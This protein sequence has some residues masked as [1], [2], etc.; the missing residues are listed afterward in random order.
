MTGDGRETDRERLGQLEHGCLTV[1]QPTHD[2]APRRVRQGG[3][4]DV[5]AIGG[6]HSHRCRRSCRYFIGWLFNRVTTYSQGCPECRRGN[7]SKDR[8]RARSA[9]LDARQVP[10]LRTTGRTQDLMLR[11]AT[12]GRRRRRR[13]TPR[14]DTPTGP[15]SCVP[16]TGIHPSGSAQNACKALMRRPELP[17]C[18][19]SVNEPG[20]TKCQPD[21]AHQRDDGDGHQR[22]QIVLSPRHLQRPTVSGADLPT[23]ARQ[24]THTCRLRAE[25]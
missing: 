17:F 5:E 8:A 23:G 21:G 13:R 22:P 3:E 7:R 18:P 12:P 25:F 24:R 19:T 20:E 2:R 6:R 14:G 15:K 4:D 10:I 16:R 1:S 9:D 11:S